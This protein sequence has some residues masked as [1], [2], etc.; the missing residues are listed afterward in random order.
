[1]RA[2]AARG[3][4][5]G[6]SVVCQYKI[7]KSQ[8]LSEN[9]V[10]KWHKCRKTVKKLLLL[11]I[12]GNIQGSYKS[13]EYV[14]HA[15]IGHNHLVP[16]YEISLLRMLELLYYRESTAHARVLLASKKEEAWPWVIS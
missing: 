14:G 12:L 8:H 16:L 3:K 9:R 2:C 4:V 1:M 13:C 7:G 15:Y 10:N 6:L 5:I 11:I